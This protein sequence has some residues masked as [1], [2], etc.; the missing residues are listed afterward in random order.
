MYCVLHA[1]PIAY[2]HVTCII[3]IVL[4]YNV[5]YLY[6]YYLYTAC[7]YTAYILL[8]SYSHGNSNP[9]SDQLPTPHTRGEH[10]ALEATVAARAEASDQSMN[11]R[12]IERFPRKAIQH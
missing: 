1:L 10:E 5:V 11:L 6:T 8:I 3:L 2:P 12:P 7:T 9:P 4:L